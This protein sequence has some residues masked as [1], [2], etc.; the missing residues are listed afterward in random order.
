VPFFISFNFSDNSTITTWDDGK[1]VIEY[2]PPPETA[3]EY[4]RAVALERRVKFAQ[5]N[6]EIQYFFN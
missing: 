2:H 4:E 3:T 1:S 5:N 6:T